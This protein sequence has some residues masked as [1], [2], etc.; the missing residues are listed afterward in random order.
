M[1]TNGLDLCV[2]QLIVGYV[3]YSLLLRQKVT[4]CLARL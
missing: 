3:F 2:L 1:F 4:Q